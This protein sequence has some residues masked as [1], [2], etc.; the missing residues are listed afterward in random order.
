LLATGCDYAAAQGTLIFSFGI[1]NT[2]EELDK[3][4]EVFKDAVVFLRNM[5]PLYKKKST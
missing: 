5:S 1:M 3:A 2:M 4:M